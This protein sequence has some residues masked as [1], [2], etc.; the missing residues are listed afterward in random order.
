[1]GVIDDSV[2]RASMMLQGLRDQT[3][4]E[5]LRITEVDL[6]ELLTRAVE[7]ANLPEGV[8][9]VLEVGDGLE[10]V[11]FDALKIRRIMDNLVKNAVDAMP[12]DGELSVKAHVSDGDILLEVSDTGEGVF[13][14]VMEDLFKPFRT[15]KLGG[16][17]LGLAYCK[18]AVEAHNGTIEVH[19][20]I[21]EG[22]TFTIILPLTH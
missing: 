21:G 11:L 17:G 2:D 9:G 14:E 5:P 19:S 1:M 7:E 22:T 18:R 10:S 20:K 8:R 16:L 12:R 6:G 15:T 3:R 4:E 13:E